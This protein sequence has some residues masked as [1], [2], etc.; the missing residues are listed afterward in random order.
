MRGHVTASPRLKSR[1]GHVRSAHC[2]RGHLTDASLLCSASVQ[3]ARSPFRGSCRYGCILF[4]FA[5]VV[6]CRDWHRCCVD[7]SYVGSI[8]LGR[9]AMAILSCWSVA[10]FIVV[11]VVRLSSPPAGVDIFRRGVMDRDVH[12]RLPLHD[13]WTFGPFRS[14]LQQPELFERTS[15]MCFVTSGLVALYEAEIWI[16]SGSTSGDDCPAG[17]L[18]YSHF[19]HRHPLRCRLYAVSAGRYCWVLIN[20]PENNSFFLCEWPWL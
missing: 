20:Y 10:R 1:L 9:S 5:G 16:L 18:S 11:G 8:L 15:Q 13:S 4:R 19:C 7:S 14:W 3:P 17:F 6:P 12:R 2:C